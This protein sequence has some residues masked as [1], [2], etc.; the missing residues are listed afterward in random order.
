MKLFDDLKADLNK[1]FAHLQT[2]TGQTIIAGAVAQAQLAL[3]DATGEEKHFHAADIVAGI[4]GIIKAAAH[5][6]VKFAIDSGII[7]A[8]ILAPVA[9]QLDDV[10]THLVD[11]ALDAASGAITQRLTKP[12]PAPAPPSAAVVPPVPAAAASPFTPVAPVDDAGKGGIFSKII[13]K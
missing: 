6:G 8:P 5:L 7:A 3:P 12:A 9:T 10:A 4:F 13:G 2:P 11:G 1:M